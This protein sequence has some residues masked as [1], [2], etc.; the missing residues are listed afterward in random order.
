[1]SEVDIY[2]CRSSSGALIGAERRLASLQVRDLLNNDESALTGCCRSMSADC[3]LEFA[4]LRRRIA[5][6]AACG[7]QGTCGVPASTFASASSS[8]RSEMGPPEEHEDHSES[9]HAV[10]EVG[11]SGHCIRSL[12]VGF[13]PSCVRIRRNWAES[14]ES[15]APQQSTFGPP[16]AGEEVGGRLW[17]SDRCCP[18]VCALPDRSGRSVRRASLRRFPVPEQ[19]RSMRRIRVLA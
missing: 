11:F 17:R 3:K 16:R 18:R 9:R 8:H 19:N 6:R 13:T 7:S 4:T 12:L 1:M 5:R 2:Q 14:M 10:E 15:C